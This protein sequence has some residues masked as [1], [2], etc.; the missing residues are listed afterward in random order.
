MKRF[1]REL[2]NGLFV[3][4]VGSL[5]SAAFEAFH[6]EFN[7]IAWSLIILGLAVA[8]SAHA[9]FSATLGFMSSAEDREQEWLRR[10]SAPRPGLI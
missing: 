8:T 1:Q 5:M 3:L 6:V 10:A 4:I 2:I 9:T 7:I